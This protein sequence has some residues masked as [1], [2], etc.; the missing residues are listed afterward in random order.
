MSHSPEPVAGAPGSSRRADMAP[1]P[2]NPF[3][4]RRINDLHRDTLVHFLS[5]LDAR[6]AMQM[7][8]VSLK[9][10][11][12]WRDVRRLHFS[13]EIPSDD[14]YDARS[15]RFKKFVNRLL[16]LRNGTSLE[17]F[18]LSSYNL[19]PNPKLPGDS[20][21]P[22]LWIRHALLCNARSVEVVVW[23]DRLALDHAGL[24][25]ENLANLRFH[26]VALNRGFFRQLQTGCQALACLILQGCP[27]NDTEISSQTLKFL[28][29]GQSCWFQSDDQAS[30]SAPRL[31]HFGFFDHD[32]AKYRRI[33]LLKNMESLETAYISLVGFDDGI[34]V[35]D[36]RQFLYGLSGVTALELYYAAPQLE[37]AN[38]F[39]WCPTF[40]KLKFLTL[41]RWCLHG[42][43]Y[44]LIVFL[45]NSPNLVKL[46][47]QLKKY[48]SEIMGELGKRS[49]TCEHLNIVEIICWECDHQVVNSLEK[50]LLAS[51]ITPSQIHIKH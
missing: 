39:Q 25:A 14:D 41:G 18:R 23:D 4:G 17:E 50:F 9:W 7:S 19:G 8:V 49:F 6:Q 1:V 3:A 22:S 5:H 28:S 20:A 48:G 11:D 10:R 38:N 12:L 31:T 45:Q 42:D 44:A 21:E 32:D 13:L 29:I 37:M 36:I 43:Y 26:K 47:L 40:R 51:G 15:R 24:T 16:M 2:R 35:D 33:P 34:L 30:I 46:T 27:I